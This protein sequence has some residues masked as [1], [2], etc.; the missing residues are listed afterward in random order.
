[1][2]SDNKWVYE[3]FDSLYNELDQE[4]EARKDSKEKE[5]QE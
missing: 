1:M 2:D 3:D 4:I 5:P